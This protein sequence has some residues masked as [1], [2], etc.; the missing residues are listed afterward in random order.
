MGIRQRAGT[1]KTHSARIDASFPRD[2]TVLIGTDCAL[3]RGLTAGFRGQ[4]YTPE[5]I[6][7]TNDVGRPEVIQGRLMALPQ[8]SDQATILVVDDEPALRDALSYTL[9]K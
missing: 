1:A 2:G 8:A 6:P 9:Q 7:V 3:N 4:A 5:R